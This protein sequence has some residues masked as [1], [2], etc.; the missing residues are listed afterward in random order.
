MELVQQTLQHADGAGVGTATAPRQ[1]TPP[2][3]PRVAAGACTSAILSV[4]SKTNRCSNLRGRTG[5]FCLG[6]FI[7]CSSKP[8]S[9]SEDGSSDDNA[10]LLSRHHSL[11]HRC[12]VTSA[13]APAA[14]DPGC[15]AHLHQ[16]AAVSGLAEGDYL[17]QFESRC[18]LGHHFLSRRCNL[19]A[20]CRSHTQHASGSIGAR[21]KRCWAVARDVVTV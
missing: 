20:S 4:S 1:V 14:Q 8:P 9:S 11:R 13:E 6:S 21:A 7:R 5:P 17:L 16:G 15:A 2:R 19:R 3:S 10:G 18:N 12:F